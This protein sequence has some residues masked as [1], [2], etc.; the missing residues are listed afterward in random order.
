AETGRE[1]IGEDVDQ[2]CRLRRP[3]ND[4]DGTVGAGRQHHQTHD[5]GADDL[6]ANLLDFDDRIVTADQLDETGR[7]TRMQPAFVDDRE[8]P[9]DFAGHL[10]LRSWLATLMYLRPAI[11]PSWRAAAM[12]SP[13]RTLVS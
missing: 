7:G 3:C 13:A 9:A 6:D 12:S 4:A 8:V 10:P 2:S 1:Q 11:W 5:G